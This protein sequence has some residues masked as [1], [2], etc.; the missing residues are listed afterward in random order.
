[1][2]TV[3]PAKTRKKESPSID[4]VVEQRIVKARAAIIMDSIFFGTL[5]V[6]LTPKVDNAGDTMSTDGTHIYYNNEFVMSLSDAQLKGVLA[7]EVM[8]CVL[9]HHARQKDRDLHKWNMAC[10]YAINPIIKESGFILPDGGLDNPKYHN[11]SAEEI[12]PL[13]D[14]EDESGGGGGSQTQNNE[15][16]FGG[17]NPNPQQNPEEEQQ[18][19]RNAMAE[20]AMTARMMGSLPANLDRFVTEYLDSKLPWQELLARFMQSV[21]KNDF[22]WSRPNKAFLLNYGIYMPSIH[23]E[24]CGSVVLAVDTSGSIG[25]KELNE[26]AAE[27]NGILDQVRPEKVTVIYCDAQINHVEEFTPDQYPVGLKAKGGGGTDFAP[28]F[29]YI[30]ENVENPQ[31]LIYLTDLYG[32]FP[33][34]EP[35]YPTMW[36]CNSDITETPFGQV[37]KL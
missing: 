26:F 35:P 37:I 32:H 25:E 4:K 24:S 16:N 2:T 36:V 15:W 19:W 29:D 30:K 33:K 22:N 14:E 1:M 18:K 23:S 9:A 5:L 6:R 31:C 11:M 20:A 27:L 17:V 10:D 8:H 3:L 28:V 13:L 21:S 12:Y 7:H 34:E